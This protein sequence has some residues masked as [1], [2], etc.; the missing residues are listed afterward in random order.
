MRVLLGETIR[1]FDSATGRYIPCTVLKTFSMIV[2]DPENPDCAYYANYVLYTDNVEDEFGQTCVYASTYDPNLDDPE[3][4][5][6]ET[7]EEWAK[8]DQILEDACREAAKAEL[9]KAQ[10]ML[11]PP[12]DPLPE[13]DPDLPFS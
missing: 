13:F 4:F 8:I 9:E 11:S 6:V 1:V 5:P 3:F 12:R 10:K 7:E 2:D